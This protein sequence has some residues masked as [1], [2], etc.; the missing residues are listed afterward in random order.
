MEL[1]EA[2]WRLLLLLE[3][4]WD[5]GSKRYRWPGDALVREAH[6]AAITAMLTDGTNGH[7]GAGKP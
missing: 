2:M 4:S 5:E 6:T 3:Q 1:R 7:T